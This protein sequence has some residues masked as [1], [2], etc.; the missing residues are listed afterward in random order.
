ML[1]PME[2]LTEE[3]KAEEEAARVPVSD[4]LSLCKSCHHLRV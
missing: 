3:S 4:F 1:K 2:D